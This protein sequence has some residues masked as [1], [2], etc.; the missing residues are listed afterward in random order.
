MACYIIISAK[1][2]EKAEKVKRK[3]KLIKKGLRW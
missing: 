1:E 3:D 2:G